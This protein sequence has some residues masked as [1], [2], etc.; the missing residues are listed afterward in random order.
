VVFDLEFDGGSL[1]QADAPTELPMLSFVPPAGLGNPAGFGGTPV[2]GRLVQVGGSQNVIG[3]GQWACETVADCPDPSTC[4]DEVCTTISGMPVGTI[5][6]GVAQPGAPESIV[7]GALTAPV[8]TGTYT[9]ELTNPVG[10]VFEKG[11]DGRP[12]WWNNPVAI[13]VSGLSI[14]VSPGEQCCA[15][16]ESC[17][18]PDLSCTMAPPLECAASGGVTHAGQV[19]ALDLDVDGDGLRDMCDPCP[20]DPFNDVDGDG[21]C[22]DV[23]NCPGTLNPGQQ[24]SDTSPLVEI[25]Q[26]AVGATASSEYSS[27]DYG[28]IQA[29]GP[30]ENPGLCADMPTNWSPLNGTSDPEWLELSY[31]TPVQATGVV[32]H[33]ALESFFVYQID[34]RDTTSALHTIWSAGDSTF[35]GGTFEPTWPPTAYQVSAVVVHTQVLNWEEIDAVQL[36]GEGP[37]PDPDGVGDACDNCLLDPNP[38][39]ADADLDDV[40]DVCDN[41][42]SDYNPGQGTVVF[43][44]EVFGRAYC[45]SDPAATCSTDADCAVGPCSKSLFEW[46]GSAG[47]VYAI[48][49]FSSSA[50]IGLYSWTQT[51]SGAGTYLADPDLPPPG[52]GYWYLLK[53]DCPGADSWQTALGAELQRDAALP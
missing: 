45:S 30:P 39:Q 25:R 35:C 40:G 4:V 1:I 23:D 38:D 14:T 18:L 21:F 41:C 53:P 26:W 49:E 20:L 8:A 44:H 28:A 19:C 36:V 33:E 46:P 10:N 22:G 12:Y 11:V 32:V 13:T 52:V 31:G 51:G 7:T 34:L 6:L 50:D 37:G 42:P 16:Y 48:G 15:E 27:T 24:D 9:L 3:H 2:A 47:Y 43:A 17:C 5:V 29:T